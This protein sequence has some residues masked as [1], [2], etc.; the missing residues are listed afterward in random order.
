MPPYSRKSLIVKASCRPWGSAM[1]EFYPKLT[2]RK[3]AGLIG[4]SLIDKHTSH[5]SESIR[6]GFVVENL[7]TTNGDYSRAE[8][9]QVIRKLYEPLGIGLE[10]A[11]MDG[12]I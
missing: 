1:P 7:Y 12:I 5:S 4:G 6:A 2:L 11:K 3:T 8:I 9:E 10:G